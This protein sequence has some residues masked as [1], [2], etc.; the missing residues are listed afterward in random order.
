ML[1]RNVEVIVGVVPG[2]VSVAPAAV[3][4]Q[5]FAVLVLVGIL[6][7]AQEQHVLQKMSLKLGENFTR[8]S[9]FET[10]H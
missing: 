9:Y 6:L 7:G 1:R 5:E 8:I 10:E 3:V 4:I 2:R